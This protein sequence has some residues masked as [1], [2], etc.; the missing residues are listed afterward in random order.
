MSDLIADRAALTAALGQLHVESWRGDTWA[1][2]CAS[3]LSEWRAA[4]EPVRVPMG[5]SLCEMWM[6]E[7]QVEALIA[8][9]VLREAA[10]AA[11]A[12]G[13]TMIDDAAALEVV[14]HWLPDFIAVA[15]NPHH[16]NASAL[17]ERARATVRAS[18]EDTCGGDPD[19]AKGEVESACET[20]I[21]LLAAF[22]EW[23]VMTRQE[24]NS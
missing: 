9:G 13:G 7:H 10:P 19:I 24:E 12:G 23:F 5:L 16:V 11:G 1:C 4:H 17:G 20:T 8:S 2:S 18:F 21:T 22:A 15:E 6:R 3:V 14:S